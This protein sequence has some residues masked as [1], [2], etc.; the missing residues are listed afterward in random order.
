MRNA[1]FC[2][3][4]LASTVVFD[5]SAVQAATV[6]EE[7][8]S[9]AVP[10]T[11]GAG[12]ISGT[13]FT[14]TAGNVDILGVLNGSFFG[15]VGNP[16]GN[17]LD[18]IGNLGLGSITN[19]DIDLIAGHTYTISYTSILQGFAPGSTP[20]E[21]YSVRLGSNLFTETVGPS[22]TANSISF[23][24]ATTQLGAALIFAS[25][26]NLDNVHGPV[27]SDI[28][29]TDTVSTTPLPAALPLFATGLGAMGLFGWRRKRKL[30]ARAS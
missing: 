10:S 11:Y 14:V 4:F 2:A 29:V 17:C 20:T 3:A 25:I 12:A 23:V 21:D 8:F 16:G 30:R 18:L 6:F 26:T 24:D 1:L 9:S 22:V 27:L 13:S 7:S 28:S 19:T 15:C 5:A